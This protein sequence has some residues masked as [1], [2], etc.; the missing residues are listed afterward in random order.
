MGSDHIAKLKLFT[1]PVEFEVLLQQDSVER[2]CFK[3]I[4]KY[5]NGRIMKGTSYVI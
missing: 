1:N 5:M 2:K 4:E 3:R